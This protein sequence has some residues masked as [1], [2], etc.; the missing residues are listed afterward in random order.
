MEGTV[1]NKNSNLPIEYAH[2]SI[3]GTTIGT[4]SNLEGKFALQV[5]IQH[6]NDTLLISHLN[7][8]T[9]SF[10]LSDVKEQPALFNLVENVTALNEIV[11]SSGEITPYQVLKEAIDS[12]NQKNYSPAILHVYHREF[13]SKANQFYYFADAAID[14]FLPSSMKKSEIDVRVI[15]S[16]AK[17]K[18]IDIEKGL[19]YNFNH[20]YDIKTII[21]LR[22]AENFLK[23]IDQNLCDFRISEF[24]NE[25]GEKML[26]V[27]FSPKKDQ[28]KFFWEGVFII[29]GE[30]MIIKSFDCKLSK[31]NKIFYPETNVLVMKLKP[32]EANVHAEFS[33]LN[34]KCFLKAAR[35]DQIISITKSKITVDYGF[36]S[37]MNTR[38]MSVEKVKPFSK[39]ERFKYNKLY[40]TLGNNNGINYITE[41]WK[42]QNGML[43]TKHEEEI[44]ASLD[45]I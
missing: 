44:I 45:G 23:F 21:N 2:I 4:I 15:E 8:R 32:I 5:P 28:Q 38:E 25:L 35:F 27:D 36:I 13:S 31:V 9:Q 18:K 14:Y 34:G 24:V 10:K 12:T 11:I 16:R 26:R 37:E 17:K 42:N 41:F 43:A 39:K 30:S 33:I 19:D 20:L 6:S 29:Y 22:N 3:K 1:L 40:Y 7:F